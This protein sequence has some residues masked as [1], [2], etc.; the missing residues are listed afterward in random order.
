MELSF[1]YIIFKY[2][3]EINNAS[4]IFYILD[5]S[6]RGNWIVR[7]SCHLVYIYHTL[8]GSLYSYQS[9]VK[10]CTCLNS[11]IHAYIHNCPLASFVVQNIGFELLIGLSLPHTQK[12][13][14]NFLWDFSKIFYT[15][16]ELWLNTWMEGG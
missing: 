12:F 7:L 10:L 5:I 4:I 6:R 11:I 9:Y 1:R 13:R 8:Y 3:Y 14:W 15:F 16:C 2:D